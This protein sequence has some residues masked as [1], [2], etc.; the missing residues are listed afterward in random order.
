M[1]GANEASRSRSP[2][3]AASCAACSASSAESADD[4]GAAG[5]AGKAPGARSRR[6]GSA[7]ALA[8]RPKAIATVA[9]LPTQCMHGTA[10][11]DSAWQASTAPL[12]KSVGIEGK[13]MESQ[14]ARPPRYVDPIRAQW[15]IELR[16]ALQALTDRP[17][18]GVRLA[19]R[20]G[21]RL[22]AA[23]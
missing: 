21:S 8:A 6:G 14:P 7:A 12:D 4:G 18:R 5:A 9:K 19:A 22:G 3:R 10:I 20:F 11:V 1:R 16:P 23:A 15:R 17:Q 2:S 13:L